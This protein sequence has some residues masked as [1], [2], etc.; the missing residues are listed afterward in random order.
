MLLNDQFATLPGIQA[1]VASFEQAFAWGKQD[2][3]VI[4]SGYISSATIDSGNSPTWELRPGLLLGRITATQQWT[5]YAATNT[6][7]SQVAA[8][9][10]ILAQR[11]QNLQGT[12]Q[13]VFFG[14]C[15]GGK[16]QGAKILGLDQQA[17]QQMHPNFQ[18]DDNYTG[19]IDYPYQNEVAKTANYTLVASDNGTLF[20]NTGAAGEVDFTLPAIANGYVFGFKAVAN[21][22]IKV[23]S[24][25][26]ANIV[27]FNNAA[28]TSVAFSTGG[29]II[30][31]GVK[32]YSNAAG[33]KWYVANE[34]AGA[35]TVTVA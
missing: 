22:T 21:Q 7:G 3:Q 13:A 12:A 33:T 10:L 28:A 9:V 24:A 35:N 23:V 14:I 32:V 1:A 6:D 30:G 34:S 4:V 26:G 31:G 8:G 16:L 15:V 2:L 27:A 5:N 29:S 25:E 11:M 20:T 19:I 17:R 18:F